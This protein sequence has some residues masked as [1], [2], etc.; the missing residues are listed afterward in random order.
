MIRHFVVFFY[1]CF[2]ILFMYIQIVLGAVLLDLHPI[3]EKT[4]SMVLLA[5]ASIFGGFLCVGILEI[6]LC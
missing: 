3:I 5:T 6:S 2:A 4:V 1:Y